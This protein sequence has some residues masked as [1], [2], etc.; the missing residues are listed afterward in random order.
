M[1]V[2]FIENLIK[3][4]HPNAMILQQISHTTETAWVK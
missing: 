4:T 2:N 3:L 1:Q